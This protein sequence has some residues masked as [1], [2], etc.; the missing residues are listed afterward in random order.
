MNDFMIFMTQ[1]LQIMW[2]IHRL[3]EEYNFTP[4][5]LLLNKSAN[6]NFKIPNPVFVMRVLEEKEKKHPISAKKSTDLIIIEP[7]RSLFRVVVNNYRQKEKSLE[8]EIGE[9]MMGD[10]QGLPPQPVGY[11][12]FPE[13][14]WF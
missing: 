2:I 5:W 3:N 12:K 14:D 1:K 6:L 11:I 8:E 10:H 13:Y 7:P 9:T 4:A